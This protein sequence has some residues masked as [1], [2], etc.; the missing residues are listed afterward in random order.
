[1]SKENTLLQT[2][3]VDAAINSNTDIGIFKFEVDS[4]KVYWNDALKEIHQ[5]QKTYI[6]HTDN[7][8]GNCKEGTLKENLL[9]AHT[10]ALLNGVSFE[11]EY[12][13]LTSK[14]NSRFLSIATHAFKSDAKCT[15]LHGFITDITHSKVKNI[16]THLLKKQLA[17][18]EKLANS[19]SW[20]WDI[21]LDTLTWS[22]N[23]YHILNRNKEN[24]LSFDT[25]L[26]YVHEEDKEK[27]VAKFDLALKTKHFPDSNYRIVLKDG[28]IKTMKSIGEVI[29][30]THGKVITIM[31][32]C[33]D[34]TES[35]VRD[36][37][38]KQK[39]KQLQLTESST[40]AGTWQLN[41]KT[42]AFKWSEN[43]Y[44]ITDF[45][46]GEPMSFE[47]LYARIHPE[48]KSH[49]DEALKCVQKNGIKH[50]FIHRL[51]TRNGCVR[52]LEITADLVSNKISNSK[53]LIGTAL[54]ITNK[55][56]I[57]HELIEKNQ[58]LNFTE[59]LTTMGYWRYKPE[60][61]DVF[62]SDNLFQIFDQPKTD[63][64]SFSS[65]FN[66]VHPDD[67]AFVKE[68]IDQSITDHQ[69]YDF[70]HRIIHRNNSIKIIQ[71][72]G[73]V[74]INEND[75]S[76]ELLGTC[77][78]ITENESREFEL[79][80]K[81]QQLNFAEKLAMI[82]Y[83]QWDTPTN[84]V[85]WSDNLHAIY[86]HDKS[87]DLTF[88]TYISYIHDED[89]ERVV[90]SL[91][92]AMLTGKFPE[93]TYKIQLN[94]GSVK[95]IKTV[96]QI[97]RNNQGEVLKMSGTCQDITEVKRKELELLQKNDQFNFAEK[98][99][100]IGS[101]Q[102]NPKTKEIK[103]SD[104]HY[105]IYEFEIGCSLHIETILSR[106]HPE[107]IRVVQ[108][109]KNQIFIDKKFE[110]IIFRLKLNN[111]TTK[112]VEVIGQAITDQ[113][114]NIILFKGTSQDITS[115]VK[116]EQLIKE[117]NQL[118]SFTEEMALM[119]SW[120]WN[121][122]TGT[123]NW[124][125]NL[126]KIYDIEPGHPIDMDLF[127]SRV[128]TDDTN[129]IK[130]ELETIV[131]AKTSKTILSF[132]IVLTN[133]NI[134]SIELLAEVIKDRQGNILEMIGT[135]QDV[136][137]RIRREQD[138]IEKNQLLNFAEQLSSL[139]HWKW[140]I[141]NDIMEKSANLLK[142]L[143]FN[144]N[145][146]LDF[147]TYLD[148]VHPDDRDKV[149]SEIEKILD[150]KNFDKFQHRIIRDNGNIRTIEIIGAV[151]LN[152]AGDVVELIGSSQDITEQVEA[153]QKIIKANKNLEESTIILTSKNE[154]LAEF[155]HITSHNLRSPVSNLNALLGLFKNSE[156][157]S[158]KVE[159]FEK[160]EIVIHHLTE[161][162]N[163]LIETITVKHNAG[164]IKENLYFEQTLSKTKEILAA[165]IMNTGAIIKY[166]FSKIEN[167]LYNPI[168]L[169]SVF[170]NLIS[171]SLKYKAPD[172]APEILII[173][174]VVNGKTTLEFKD[175]GLGIDMKNYGDKLFGL[176]KVFHKH[177]DARGVGLFLTKAQIVAMNG[178]ISA[179]SEVNVGTTFFITL[180]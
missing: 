141:V 68:K 50:T 49:V 144:K 67:K 126:Y 167:V 37:Q 143:D 30:D 61:N 48:D 99:A 180:N 39:N 124:S 139:G 44:K 130:K 153:Q 73:K 131:K 28:S 177:P 108:E 72:I 89:R 123:S 115:R 70:T 71:I 5:V 58:L 101:W 102:W 38:L 87:D 74:T 32:T 137:D 125:D 2:D 3:Q 65:Y 64:L 162:L 95:T 20:K 22:G 172:R 104:N 46:Y 119:G 106:I 105:R 13:V 56:K 24:P 76:Q 4:N 103:W 11:L 93:S 118:L 158:K 110:K 175:N 114:G 94:D 63:K 97:D 29:T 42:G 77:L 133:G 170:L 157:E 128:H 84:K 16:E 163:T 69:F 27:I 145:T 54:D 120:Q 179:E 107:D 12:E 52:T 17:Y 161:T 53:E 47:V 164:G 149:I 173:S 171:N 160:F 59:H 100:N 34:I 15:S 156:S 168:Y 166:D 78:D 142:I 19:G 147:K 116:A 79:T 178:S 40:E 23:F 148:R 98:I 127:L 1:M 92:N 109:L 85:Y 138:L 117:K 80:K 169:E 7:I 151:L 150:S 60:T 154:Q 112:T 51:I 135:A 35:K 21:N 75:G 81:N 45:E 41:T 134:R 83:W 43:L 26:E 25:F 113:E 159:I 152:E 36:H 62:W 10:Q 140:D 174:N 96:G 165:E 6:P 176:N 57:E 18:A 121:P 8:Y 33:Q 9:K 122:N 91:E 14:G 31:G 86:G 66:K 136:T 155:N 111:E 55:V 129:R 88:E 82:G 90:S 132:R 146:H